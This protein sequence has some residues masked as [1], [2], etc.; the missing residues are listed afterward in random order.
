MK[1]ISFVKA[2]VTEI[3]CKLNKVKAIAQAKKYLLT[4]L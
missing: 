3:K 2:C 1:N 4:V